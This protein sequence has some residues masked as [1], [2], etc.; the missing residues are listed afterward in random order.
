MY[1]RQNPEIGFDTHNTEKLVK[2]HLSSEG[3]EILPS[4]MGVLGLIKGKDSKM[5]IRDSPCSSF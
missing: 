2:E 4:K 5:C 1:K 3:I